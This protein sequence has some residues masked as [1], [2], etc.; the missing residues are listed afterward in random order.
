MYNLQRSG[1]RIWFKSVTY[2]EFYK[3]QDLHREINNDSDD[4]DE[5]IMAHR[6]TPL[7]QDRTYSPL[8]RGGTPERGG[9]GQVGSPF[10][11]YGSPRASP[12][13]EG[14]ADTDQGEGIQL[15]IQ[16]LAGR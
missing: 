16:Q 15:T 13:R 1:S 2:P 6:R 9:V 8:Y 3:T 10:A 14:S 5:E 12:A 7:G 4:N 11:R